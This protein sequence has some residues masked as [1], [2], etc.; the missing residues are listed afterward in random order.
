MVSFGSFSAKGLSLDIVRRVSSGS[1]SPEGRDAENWSVVK[2]TDGTWTVRC[3]G[4]VMAAFT[5]ENAA[6]AYFRSM[7][8]R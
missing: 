7:T 1:M 4:D 5:N 6:K 8:S 3:C 2:E